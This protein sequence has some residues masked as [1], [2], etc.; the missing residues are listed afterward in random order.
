[1]PD[2]FD[3]QRKIDSAGS[4][5]AGAARERLEDERERERQRRARLVKLSAGYY[6]DPV[7]K[8]L[9]KKQGSQIGF[10]RHDRR[11]ERLMKATQAEAEAR[12]FRMVLGGMYW[13]EKAKKLY[14]KSGKNFVLY[15]PDRRKGGAKAPQSGERRKS[16]PHA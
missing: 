4:R 16:R 10:V 11:H 7:E 14:R 8:E 2:R 1:M 15:S 6:F 13:D 9:L 3:I 5:L 12:A